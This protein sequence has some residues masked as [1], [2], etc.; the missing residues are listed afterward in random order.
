M[1]LERF[2]SFSRTICRTSLSGD[3]P[4]IA[5]W[6]G[7]PTHMAASISDNANLFFAVT[8]STSYLPPHPGHFARY[9]RRTTLKAFE[10]IP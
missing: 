9:S 6:R 4:N 2:T 1:L 10:L 7:A 5:F 8:I 3:L